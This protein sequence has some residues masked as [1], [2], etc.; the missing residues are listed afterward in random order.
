MDLVWMHNVRA[1]IET[2][3]MFSEEMRDRCL[4]RFNQL[5][6]TRHEGEAFR[7]AAVTGL[8]VMQMDA[9][10]NQRRVDLSDFY[11]PADV[12]GALKALLAAAEMTT[13]SDQFPH[14]C[15][16]AR[17]AIASVERND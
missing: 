13:F 12:L 14:E 4:A 1:M 5:L 11:A 2:S 3:P 6:A 10:G 8:G 17:N 9:D 16:M 7:D 15:E